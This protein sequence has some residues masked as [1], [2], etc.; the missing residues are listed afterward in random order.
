MTSRVIR[1]A[2]AT[3]WAPRDRPRPAAQGPDGPAGATRPIDIPKG[4]DP[5]W[6]YNPAQ[7]SSLGL[8]QGL[9]DRLERRLAAGRVTPGRVRHLRRFVAEYGRVELVTYFLKWPTRP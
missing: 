1:T 9:V 2:L 4:I 6:D 8:H 3:A 7:H 5:G